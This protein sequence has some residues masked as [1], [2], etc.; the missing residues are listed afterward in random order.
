MVESETVEMVLRREVVQ[1]LVRQ[2]QL[3]MNKWNTMKMNRFEY[4][5]ISVT[6]LLLLFNSSYTISVIYVTTFNN[7]NTITFNKYYLL[8]YI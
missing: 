7:I 6:I 4:I 3:R 2:H 8:C 5:T 1:R